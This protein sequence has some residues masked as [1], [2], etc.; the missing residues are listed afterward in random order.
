MHSSQPR[1]LELHGGNLAFCAFNV[2]STASSLL[3]GSVADWTVGSVVVE[4]MGTV[5][6]IP[7]HTVRVIIA[8][9]SHERKSPDVQR[10]CP[11][12]CL[13]HCS[14]ALRLGDIRVTLA[15]VHPSRAWVGLRGPPQEVACS[16]G[17]WLSRFPPFLVE[18]EILARNL[19]TP[20]RSTA[21]A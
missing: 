8:A 9:W 7:V 3:V 10:A 21:W 4:T 16:C 14:Q 1:V 17:S 15:R 6:S 2:M 11:P 19:R 12:S 20:R 18:A 5:V 13:P